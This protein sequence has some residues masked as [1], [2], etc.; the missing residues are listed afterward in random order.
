MELVGVEVV[1]DSHL[2][3]VLDQP[4]VEIA[5][6]LDDVRV[7]EQL[8]DVRPETFSSRFLNRSGR[9]GKDECVVLDVK[10]DQAVSLDR[11]VVELRLRRGS[12]VVVL[13][14]EVVE[15]DVEV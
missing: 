10:E 13:D 3:E 2:V 7:G 9:C 4:F 5:S 12:I 6:D 11:L 15:E 14:R 8:L 1:D